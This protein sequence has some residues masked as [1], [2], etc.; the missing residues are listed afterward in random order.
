M[1]ECLILTA[2]TDI[3]NMNTLNNNTSSQEERDGESET[4]QLADLFK[5]EI[6]VSPKRISVNSMNSRNHE[7]SVNGM[8]TSF[9]NTYTKQEY[10]WNFS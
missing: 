4:T 10:H 2:L 3:V 6:G 5:A 9:Y 8:V 1:E 7:E